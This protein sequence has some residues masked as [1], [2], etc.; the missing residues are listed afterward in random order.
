MGLTPG[1]S[2]GKISMGIASFHGQQL[3]LIPL[4]I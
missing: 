3:L 2:N 4:E 1:F